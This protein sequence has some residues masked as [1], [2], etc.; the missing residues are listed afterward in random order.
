MQLNY[1]ITVQL[2]IR[3]E[4]L[5]SKPGNERDEGA[6]VSVRCRSKNVVC[7][8]SKSLLSAWPE[9][10]NDSPAALALTKNHVK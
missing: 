3:I 9:I 1:G 7:K 2:F 4:R 6:I 5:M 8:F 10:A